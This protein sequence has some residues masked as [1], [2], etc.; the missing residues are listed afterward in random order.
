VASSL[1]LLRVLG[2]NE[3]NPP[4]ASSPFTV[5]SRSGAEDVLQLALGL[6]ETWHEADSRL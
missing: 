3:D 1:Q 2:I 6:E 4:Y 5:T